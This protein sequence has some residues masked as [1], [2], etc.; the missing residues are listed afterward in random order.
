[1][2][3]APDAWERANA[4]G[5]LGAT[6]AGQKRY[7]EAEPLLIAGYE[8]MAT[9]KAVN[10]NAASRMSRAQ[11]GEALLQ[12]YRDSGNTARRTE[13]EKKLRDTR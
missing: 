6:L 12:L 13:W 10:P 1:M 5:M 11:V 2:R 9:G 7:A 4:A 3:V 8:G